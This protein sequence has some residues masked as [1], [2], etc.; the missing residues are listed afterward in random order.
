MIYIRRLDRRQYLC[1]TE[2]RV[3]FGRLGEVERCCVDLLRRRM[4]LL[5]EHMTAPLPATARLPQMGGDHPDQ[6]GL[7]SLQ[8]TARQVGGS[9][10]RM[11]NDGPEISSALSGK[12]HSASLDPELDLSVYQLSYGRTCSLGPP[13]D[14]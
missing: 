13:Q 9:V 2:L 7:V 14:S 8:R 6:R 5:H 3:A 4:P 12:I 1:P 11:M 10:G